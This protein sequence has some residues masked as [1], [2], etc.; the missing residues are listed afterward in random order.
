MSQHSVTDLTPDGNVS[1][2]QSYR[3]AQMRRMKHLFNVTLIQFLAS[4]RQQIITA[5]LWHCLSLLW[6][7]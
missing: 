5:A 7:F 1:E 4:C 2:L 6:P 3:T